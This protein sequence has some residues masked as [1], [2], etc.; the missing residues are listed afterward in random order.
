MTAM[1]SGGASGAIFGL[2]GALLSHLW[3]ERQRIHRGEFRW[4]FWAA[5]GFSVA[6]IIFGFLVPGIDNAAHIGG[7]TTGLLMGVLLVKSEEE[8]RV[9]R[10]PGQWASAIALV[11]LIGG[12][13][14]RILRRPI[15]GVTRSRLDRRLASF[16]S[17]MLR[18]V[19]PGKACCFREGEKGCH[20]MSWPT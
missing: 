8:N 2:Y 9:I 17:R 16:S 5:I 1:V 4:L 6:T 13:V 3:L 7:L 18:S 15:A 11:I 20:L 10:R 19:V 14:A 12:M